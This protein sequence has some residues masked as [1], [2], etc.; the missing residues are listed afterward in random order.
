MSDSARAAGWPIARIFGITV[1]IHP[2]WLLIFLF[3]SYSL[4][5]GYLPQNSLAGGGPWTDGAKRYS[6]IKTVLLQHP[7]MSFRQAADALGFTLWPEWQYWLLGVLGSLGLFLCVLA[8]EISH[9]LVAIRNGI[10]VS[11]IT[12]FLF[13]GVSELKEESPRP[14]V[15]F[16]VAA[17]GPLMSIFLSIGAGLLYFGLGDGL[18]PQARALLWYFTFINLMLAV[19]NLLPGFPLDGGRLLR[20]ILWSRYKDLRRATAVAVAWGRGI[21]MGFIALGVLEFVYGFSTGQLS[22]D[23]IWMV[24]IGMFLRYA[25]RASY[26]QLT[27]KDA[28]AGLTVRELIQPQVVTVDPDLTLDRLVDEYFYTHRYRS[29]PVLEGDRLAGMISLKDLQAVPRAEWPVRQVRQAMHQ[30]RQENL[31][32]PT[33]DLA[34]VFR[35]MAEEH[36]GHLPVVDDGRLAGI[37]TRHDIMT[38]IQLKTDLGGPVRAPKAGDA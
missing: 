36:K 19:F 2:S 31:I 28:F 9:S 35:K 7:E 24:V 38:L 14:G 32:H 30:V 8:H 3:L 29:F 11:G 33:D 5:V 1:R 25:A 21:G 6:E 13:G 26:Q 20:A 27:V 17:A 15:E 34:G 4:A 12:L 37:I 18:P 16:R 10:P 23:A 22:F